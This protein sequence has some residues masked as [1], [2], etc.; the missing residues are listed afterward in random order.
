MNG[1]HPQTQSEPTQLTVAASSELKKNANFQPEFMLRPKETTTAIRGGVA[2]LE[3]FASGRPTPVLSWEKL[4]GFLPVNHTITK[5]GQLVFTGVTEDMAGTYRCTA[6][7]SEG[8]IYADGNLDLEYAPQWEDVI[9]SR[10]VDRTSSV[11]LHCDASGIPAPAYIWLKDGGEL[12]TNDHITISETDTGTQ[13]EVRGVTDTDEGMYQCKASNYLGDLFS[14][15]KLT[16]VSIPP[17]LEVSMPDIIYGSLGGQVTLDC[18]VRA[19]PPPI[20]VWS[21]NE[22]PAMSKAEEKYNFLES[23]SMVITNLTS[24]DAGN[25]K[26]FAQND[27][28]SVESQGSLKIYLPTEITS[29]PSDQEAYVGDLV[30]LDC[31]ASHDPSLRLDWS[32]TLNEYP[33]RLLDEHYTLTGGNLMIK[34]IGSEQSGVYQCCATTSVGSPCATATVRVLAPPDPPTNVWVTVGGQNSVSLEWAPGRDNGGKVLMYEVEAKC[35]VDCMWHVVHTKPA[36][37]NQTSCDVIHLLPNNNYEFRV[38]AFNEYGNSEASVPSETFSTLPD[39]P[40]A[41]PTRIK[42]GAKEF[43]EL[44]VTWELFRINLKALVIPHYKSIKIYETDATFKSFTDFPLKIQA[45]NSYGRG[46]YSP[47]H[48]VHTAEAAPVVAPS[49][50]QAVRV[51]AYSAELT[52]LPLENKNGRTT[53]YEVNF[54]EDP[55]CEHQQ[56]WLNYTTKGRVPR[57]KMDK[58]EENSVYMVYVSGF[59][60]AGSGPWSS[61]DF[62]LLTKNQPP[63]SPPGDVQI[64]VDDMTLYASWQPVEPG[65]EESD[66]LGY[67]VQFRLEGKPAAPTRT[68]YAQPASTTA[69]IELPARANYEVWV[70]A[71]SE[72]GDGRTSAPVSISTLKGTSSGRGGGAN[73]ISASI[74][75][76]LLASLVAVLRVV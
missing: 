43:G 69:Q 44:V 35:E 3:C 16:V 62:T 67:K 76:L 25:Y 29:A 50:I 32:W 61:G 17:K 40:V 19:A 15:A 48:I 9:Y 54:D 36:F 65:F 2:M 56:I 74:S 1:K 5:A 10:S 51:K 58:L 55:N 46:P 57:I 70:L 42:G 60:T 6:T 38:T 59:N 8:S 18:V 37:V 31:Q 72:G 14:S 49:G 26:C 45:E 68:I 23:G 13:L 71:F 11:V 7:N 24:N 47:I 66:V 52:W 73:N 39:A 20:I 30:E 34:D 4:D 21:K 27:I 41:H 12:V 33:I 63:Q 53:G 22:G 28:E 64:T 75:L